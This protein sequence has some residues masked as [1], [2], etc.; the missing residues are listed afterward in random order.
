MR[1]HRVGLIELWILAWVVL[2]LAACT[3]DP[4]KPSSDSSAIPS[5]AVTMEDGEPVIQERAVPSRV[6]PGAITSMPVRPIQPPALPPPPPLP[7]EFVIRTMVKQTFIT[8]VD[9]GGR[10]TNAIHTDATGI[11]SW[12]KFRILSGGSGQYIIQTLKGTYLTAFNGGGLSGPPVL[13]GGQA[14]DVLHTDATQ[15]GSWEMFRLGMDSYGWRNTIQTVNGRYVT[16]VGG[17]GKTNDPIHTD[18]TQAGN[19]E[20]FNIWKCGNLGSGYQYTISAPNGFV[21]A[22]GGGGRV[23]TRADVFVFGAIGA[24]NDYTLRPNPFDNNWQRFRLIQQGDGSY[25]LQTSNGINYVTA[26]QG[27]GLASGTMLW[28]DLV[29]DRTQVQA[30]E[31][32]RFIDQGD[33]SYV[34][35]TAS[36]HYLGKSNAPPGTALGVFSTN[37]TDI[38]SATRFRLA[39]VF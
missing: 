10:T 21:F 1:H 33:C 13:P 25:A 39:M 28:D 5:S 23:S 27:G 22:Y 34:I 26:I 32:F 24:L 17:G 7:G 8:A 6:A 35:Q 38:R 4:S 9:G 15:I 3:A 36:G 11:G 18:A 19:W 12:E 16:A 29:T 14:T 2:G 37:V 31:K 30:W 20:Y